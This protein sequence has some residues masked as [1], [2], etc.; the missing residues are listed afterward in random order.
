MAPG[1]I[2]LIRLRGWPET[3]ARHFEWSE[4]SLADQSL[5]LF[6]ADSFEDGTH[7]N[8]TGIAV[9]ERRSRFVCRRFIHDRI[10]VFQ[11]TLNHVLALTSI[12]VTVLRGAG[13]MTQEHLER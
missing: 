9:T 12:L 2:D 13:A 3:R 7:D 6:A 1:L 11:P 10:Q 4:E 8:I 5:P